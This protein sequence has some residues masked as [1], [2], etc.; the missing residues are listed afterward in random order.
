MQLA[1]FEGQKAM[2]CELLRRAHESAAHKMRLAV[3][4]QSVAGICKAQRDHEAQLDMA[5]HLQETFE[6]G[7]IV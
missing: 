5:R 4:Q 7:T 2:L 3:D 6:L 1:V